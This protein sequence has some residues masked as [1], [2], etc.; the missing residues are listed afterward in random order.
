MENS[1]NSSRTGCLYPDLMEESTSFNGSGPQSYNVASGS[2]AASLYPR[3]SPNLSPLNGSASH[4]AS[5]T[6]GSHGASVSS[7]IFGGTARPDE[8]TLDS[9]GFNDKL[10]KKLQTLEELWTDR[11]NVTDFKVK[12]EVDKAYGKG[13][14]PVTYQKLTECFK[15]IA[16]VSMRDRKDINERKQKLSTLVL[17]EANNCTGENEFKRCMRCLAHAESEKDDLFDSEYEQIVNQA[18]KR[19]VFGS[20]FLSGSVP[21]SEAF[22]TE[23][24]DII[25]AQQRLDSTNSDY[26]YDSAGITSQLQRSVPRRGVS[27]RA[28]G[29]SVDEIFSRSLSHTE[30][31]RSLSYSDFCSMPAQPRQSKGSINPPEHSVRDYIEKSCM[32]RTYKLRPTSKALYLFPDEFKSKGSFDS[33]VSE[34][35]HKIRFSDKDKQRFVALHFQVKILLRDLA[36]EGDLTGCRWKKNAGEIHNFN[37]SARLG[38]KEA[39]EHRNKIKKATL[40]Y[41]DNC[42]AELE[43][44]A[45]KCGIPLYQ[46]E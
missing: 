42:L 25:A 40:T 9:K 23:L 14:F 38:L 45:Y 7:L 24:K 11:D 5:S 46:W 36:R 4:G 30:A 37:E 17:V 44:T 19:R 41:L 18:E 16:T 39:L 35:C 26:L 3:L 1:I 10:E 20:A 6:S 29:L 33:Q 13:E 32:F 31:M 27:G 21:A 22:K 12:E 15:I 34:M 8:M 43:N 2:G 28:A